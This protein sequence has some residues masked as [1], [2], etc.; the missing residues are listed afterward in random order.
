M[1]TVNEIYKK[2]FSKD[3][4]KTSSEIKFNHAATLNS[5]MKDPL[6]KHKVDKQGKVGEFLKE[7][8]FGQ[9]EP[10]KNLRQTIAVKRSH[11]T[12]SL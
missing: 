2:T 10:K 11:T 1:R 7:P 6:F 12:Y 5:L 8:N 3:T 4:S 9:L